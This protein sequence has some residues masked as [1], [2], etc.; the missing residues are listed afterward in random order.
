MQWIRDDSYL[1]K[2]I[3]KTQQITGRSN[4]RLPWWF[5]STTLRTVAKTVFWDFAVMFGVNEEHAKAG[6]RFGFIVGNQAFIGD[7]ILYYRDAIFYLT[8]KY[9]WTFFAVS[10]NGEV[11]P[12]E[13]GPNTQFWVDKNPAHF[14]SG[15]LSHWN[16]VD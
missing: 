8:N 13:R 15:D 6:Y 2:T 3:G 12:D 5:H 1:G 9:N 11:I 16:V 7:E 10:R 4:K 14:L